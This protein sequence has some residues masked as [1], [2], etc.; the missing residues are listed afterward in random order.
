MCGCPAGP[1]GATIELASRFGA[2][3]DLTN[4]GAS[5][6]FALPTVPWGGQV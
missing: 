3:S 1:N 2:A 5:A 4:G 6:W